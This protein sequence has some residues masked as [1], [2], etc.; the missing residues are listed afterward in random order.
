MTV[1]HQKL[2]I[3]NLFLFDGQKSIEQVKNPLVEDDTPTLYLF[4]CDD[5]LAEGQMV[6]IDDQHG[7]IGIYQNGH[8]NK[9]DMNGLEILSLALILLSLPLPVYHSM[10]QNLYR[11][12]I[13][14]EGHMEHSENT[15]IVKAVQDNIR[16]C[17]E[18]LRYLD[19]HIGKTDETY[20]LT[21]ASEVRGPE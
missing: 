3:K 16:A 5:I 11:L 4:H 15:N 1:T 12:S 14:N 8:L 20:H 18:N 19:L 10:L 6:A 13:M 21:K 7:M 17:N 9:R 2:T